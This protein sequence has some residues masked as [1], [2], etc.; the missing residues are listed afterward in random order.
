MAKEILKKL[1]WLG[2]DGF[3]LDAAG[4]VIYFDPYDIKEGAKADIILVSHDHYDHFSPDDIKKIRKDETLVITNETVA[5]K[6]DG[7]KQVLKAGES[8]KGKGIEIKA[9]PAYNPD[10][11]FHP[12]ES[13]GLGFIVTVGGVKIYHTGDSDF[14]PEMKEI[15]C[16]IALIPV[17]GTYVMDADEA[18]EAALAIKP[19]VAVPMHWG[20]FI[21][22]RADA[23]KLKKD[24]EGKI[25]VVI[26]SK[27]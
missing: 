26:L 6:I 7:S 3:R 25:E 18:V 15:D 4:A 5:Q 16:D 17:S 27:E 10:K 14:I 8:W 1:H 22:S 19:S 23:E 9:V 24:L 2:H 12:K 13:G 21:G 20:S 11:Q